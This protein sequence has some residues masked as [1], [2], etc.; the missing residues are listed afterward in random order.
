MLTQLCLSIVNSV[1]LFNF[2]FFPTSVKSKLYI[3]I[4]MM[5]Y[6]VN[7]IINGSDKLIGCNDLFPFTVL[8]LLE[9]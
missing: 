4:S 3:V 2:L 6:P 9:C 1:L 8:G 7:N 5:P